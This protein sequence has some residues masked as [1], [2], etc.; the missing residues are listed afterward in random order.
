MDGLWAYDPQNLTEGAVPLH[1]GFCAS[2]DVW[3][4][5]RV[6]R[7]RP[8]FV[9]IVRTE[10]VVRLFLGHSDCRELGGSCGGTWRNPCELKAHATRIAMDTGHLQSAGALICNPR[11]SQFRII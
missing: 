3:L 11:A 9:K 8:C 5:L 7:V 2:G 1:F 6:Q 4:C 10:F